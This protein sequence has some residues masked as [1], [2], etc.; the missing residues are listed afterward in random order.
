MVRKFVLTQNVITRLLNR[1]Q[2]VNCE[3]CE[4]PLEIGERVVSRQS[5]HHNITTKYYHK[6]CYESLFLEVKA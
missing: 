4:Q 1:V 3:V 2:S 5:G 6:N